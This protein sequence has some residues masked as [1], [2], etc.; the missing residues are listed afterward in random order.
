MKTPAATPVTAISLVSVSITPGTSYNENLSNLNDIYNNTIFSHSFSTNIPNGH[1][2]LERSKSS[3]VSNLPLNSNSPTNS[4]SLSPSLKSAYSIKRATSF[5]NSYLS[6]NRSFSSSFEDSSLSN[7]FSLTS[8]RSSLTSVALLDYKYEHPLSTTDANSAIESDDDSEIVIEGEEQEEEEEDESAY[9]I[10]SVESKVLHYRTNYPNI[11]DNSGHY[12]PRQRSI[13][14]DINKDNLLSFLK[15]LHGS[16]HLSSSSLNNLGSNNSHF[17]VTQEVPLETFSQ[18]FESLPTLHENICINTEDPE[19]FLTV[20]LCGKTRRVREHR[21]NSLYLLQY[22][23][24]TSA[25]SKGF[26]TSID[27][28]EIDIFDELLL[29]KYSELTDSSELCDNDRLFDTIFY[30]KLK[31][32]LQ[33]FDPY[34][35]IDKQFLFH[36]K[37]ASISRYKLWTTSFLQPR[38][39]AVPTMSSITNDIYPNASLDTCQVPWLNIKDLKSGKAINRF[40]KS[41][42]LLKGS[43]VQYVSKK[44]QSKRWVCLNSDRDQ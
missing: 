15:K 41:A 17:N 39:D 6:H 3:N 34:R 32:R 29:E 33:V 21:I 31:N 12:Q 44:C 40:T 30:W 16:I 22:A 26:L 10:N 13:S 36:L 35:T 7:T 18:K 9:F 28:K 14:I 2:S 4:L 43:N 23:T 20:H 1:S 19:S 24:D 37:L 5:R 27:D 25:R 42:G 8:H 11:E 38:T